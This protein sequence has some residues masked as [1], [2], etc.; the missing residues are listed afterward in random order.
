MLFFE[1]TELSFRRR[2]SRGVIWAF[3]LLVIGVVSSIYVLRFSLQAQ[4]GSLAST[5]ASILNTVQITIFNMIY[6]AIAIKLTDLENHRTDTG[7]VLM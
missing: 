1:A 2:I 7:S 3:I 5:I 4:L 6:M